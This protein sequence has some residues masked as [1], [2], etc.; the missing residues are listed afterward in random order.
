MPTSG[1]SFL[2]DEE[3]VSFI[4]MMVGKLRELADDRGFR[5]LM[6]GLTNAEQ[7]AKAIKLA[8]RKAG[9]VST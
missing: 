1:F 3:A 6:K 8:K 9:Y 5:Q 4:A 2:T 7:A